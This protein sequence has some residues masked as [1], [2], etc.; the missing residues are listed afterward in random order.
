MFAKAFKNCQNDLLEDVHILLKG[1]LNPN[2]EELMSSEVAFLL[3][4]NHERRLIQE[5]ANMSHGQRFQHLFKLS[6]LQQLRGTVTFSFGFF[7]II[8]AIC[9]V[10]NEE[11][12]AL[13]TRR[14][15][16]AGR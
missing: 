13:G 6:R 12:R 9:L 11:T 3:E 1:D 8:R 15:E 4:F 14:L 5:G 7:A 10:V 2:N 16:T